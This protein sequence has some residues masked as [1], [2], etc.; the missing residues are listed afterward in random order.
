VTD[1]TLAGLEKL[2]KELDYLK[3]TKRPEIAQR[4]KEAIAFGDLSENAA[5]H[6]A[7]EDQGFL[8]GRIL[9]LERAIRSAKIIEKAAQN[10]YV[11]LGSFVS[12]ILNGEKT[13]LEIVGP[14]ETNPLEG[15]ISSESP[16]GQAILG[17]RK[18][19]KGNVKTGENQTQ[20]QI[21]EIR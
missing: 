10:K 1:L 9:E 14:R 16:V 15:R 7:K 21:I 5:Y 6:E 18:G 4:L 17:K 20:Y 12:L 13:E 11:Q 2:K 19:E 8:E 3:N